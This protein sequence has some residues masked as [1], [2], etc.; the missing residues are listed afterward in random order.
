MKSFKDI[1]NDNK[2]IDGHIHL[3]DDRKNVSMN[4]KCIGF[5][6]VF[7]DRPANFSGLNMVDLYSNYIN[8]FMTPSITLLATGIDANTVIE[9]HKK[10]PDIIKG[11][12]ELKCYDTYHS[13]DV[14]KGNLDWIRPI[15][16]YNIFDLP[17]YIHY[18]MRHSRLEELDKLLE[19]YPTIPIVLC[20]CGMVMDKGGYADDSKEI[21]EMVKDE[22]LKKNNLWVDLSWAA[23]NYFTEHKRELEKLPHDRIFVGTDYNP[24]CEVSRTTSDTYLTHMYSNA[25][26]LAGLVDSDKNIKTLFN[27]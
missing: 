9:V 22:M 8:N 7:F 15:L 17:V 24:Q 27:L 19:D 14:R 3:F 5:A 12:G 20:H 2:Y 13:F 11:F 4:K 25:C 21:F 23:G 6:D 18:D 26:E 16:D 1:I 10:F